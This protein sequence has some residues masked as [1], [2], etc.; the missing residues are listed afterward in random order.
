MNRW[1]VVFPILII[2]SVL[3]VIGIADGI[4]SISDI[5]QPKMEDN[6]WG[7]EYRDTKP[8]CDRW[9]TEKSI[10]NGTTFERHF[11]QYCSI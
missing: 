5:I 7:I 4:E 1:I 10:V 6:G 2:I 3:T 11:R 8:Y 9:V